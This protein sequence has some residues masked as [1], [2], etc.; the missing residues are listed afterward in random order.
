MVLS[1]GWGISR[2][3]SARSVGWRSS[4][5]P[6]PQVAPQRP[7]IGLPLPGLQ[8]SPVSRPVHLL[9]Y[10]FHC[11]RW[12]PKLS[13]FLL[14][15]LVKVASAFPTRTQTPQGARDSSAR[16][17]HV[18]T[19]Q[20]RREAGDPSHCELLRGIIRGRGRIAEMKGTLRPQRPA[21]GGHCRA[22][23]E[24]VLLLKPG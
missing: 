5:T 6:G 9:A 11:T 22:A 23:V 13:C 14:L 24:A 2:L 10:F 1:S 19:K 3:P 8:I 18:C 21:A 16:H 20:I 17:G 12:S 4:W 15:L 7:L